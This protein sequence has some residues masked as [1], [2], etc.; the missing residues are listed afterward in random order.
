MNG[1]R[2]EPQPGRGRTVER[3]NMKEVEDFIARVFEDAALAGG[4]DEYR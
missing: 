1:K 3:R 4:G 2:R